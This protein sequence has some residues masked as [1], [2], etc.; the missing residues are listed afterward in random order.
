MKFLK[1]VGKALQLHK[2]YR[3][4]QRKRKCA[5]SGREIRVLF[6]K[7]NREGDLPLTKRQAALWRRTILRLRYMNSNATLA[8]EGFT[9]NNIKRIR[10]VLNPIIPPN[11]PILMCMV[12][13]DLERIKLSVLHHRKI[14]IGHFVF[15]DNG[16]TDGTLKWLQKQSDVDLYQTTVLHNTN[17]R[18]G[19][20]SRLV[21]HYGLNR[22]YAFLDS[23]ELIA[24]PGMETKPI[25]ALMQYAKKHNYTTLRTFM[26][27]MY[28]KDKIFDESFSNYYDILKENRYY[29]TL[30]YQETIDSRYGI[31]VKG[32]PRSRLLAEGSPQ[33]ELTKYALTYMQ[34]GDCYNVHRAFPLHKNFTPCVYVLLHYKFLP[35]DLERAKQNVKAG[36]HYLGAVEYKRMLEGYHDKRVETFKNEQSAEL[37]NS[38]DLR[39][40]QILSEM[41]NKGHG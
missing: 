3:Y 4:V 39:K 16:S 25:S 8:A 12:K 20:F 6:A 7:I 28:S 27:D 22:W 23:D 36:L 9:Q 13:N 40:I 32:G 11:A 19:L 10:I 38:E 18:I 34:K 29:D 15:L 33:P 1:S 24:Y 26:L 14:G 37:C 30:T 17:R 31:S 21:N 35:W 2:A 5:P 41:D